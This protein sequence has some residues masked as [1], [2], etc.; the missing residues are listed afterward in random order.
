MSYQLNQDQ[1]DHIE[2]LVNTGEYHLA[3]RYIAEQIDSSVQNG[4]VS[5]E[6]QRWFE[7]A[8][9]INCNYD[10]IIN[11]YARTYAVMGASANGSTMWIRSLTSI[12][13]KGIRSICLVF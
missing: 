4:Q 2:S 3:Y 1:K 11:K 7:W 13:E 12:L 5:R 9:H 6:T 10:T 8:E